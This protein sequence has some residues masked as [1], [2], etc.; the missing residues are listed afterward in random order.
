MKGKKRIEDAK[1]ENIQRRQ[2]VE[3]WR[4]KRS[5]QRGGRLKAEGG[6]EKRKEGMRDQDSG[7][8]R[9]G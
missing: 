1:R 6:K 7:R 4:M 3:K 2:Q 5:R 8:E 9:E